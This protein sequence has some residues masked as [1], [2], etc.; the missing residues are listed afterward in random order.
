M[1]FL[2]RFKIQ[3]KYKSTDPEVRL[4]AVRELG[5]DT[6]TD[7]E[8]AALVALAREDTDPRVR[9]AAAARIEDVEVL[10]GIASADADEGV[11]TDVLDPPAAVAAAPNNADPALTA[12]GALRDPKLIGHVAKASPLDTVRVEAVNRLTD[13]RALS[14]VARHA[15]DPRVA[16]LA[17]DKVQDPAELL[18]IATKTEHKDAGIAAL[19][20]AGVQDRA[21][22]EQLA[23]R[24]NSKSVAKRA[25]AMVQAIDDAGTARKAAAEQ[26][27]QRV[28]AAIAGA[29][30]LRQSGSD[31]VASDRLAAVENGW[32]ELMAGATHD[33]SAADRSRFDAAVS[34]ARGA[35]ER[36]AQARAERDA[37]EAELGA[38]RGAKTALCERLDAFYGEDA[39]DKLQAARSEWE[40]LAADPDAAVHES[41]GRRFEEACARVRTRHENLQDMARTNARLEE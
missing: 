30:A 20:R 24:A 16:S 1:S 34:T 38:A 37:Q 35:I 27:A 18:N 17:V 9:R 13:V 28:A 12:L 10:A 31:S 33:I 15:A 6:A 3:P 8:R 41:F 21:T 26:H 4:A 32:R 29:E 39:L 19:E 14:S 36:E 40:G 11:R 23:D 25:R 22:L 2:D 5:L 7:D